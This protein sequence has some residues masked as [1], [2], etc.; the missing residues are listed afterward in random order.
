MNYENKIKKHPWT[1]FG[2]GKKNHPFICKKSLFSFETLEIC[3]KKSNIFLLLLLSR[4]DDEQIHN[5]YNFRWN[6][7][8]NCVVR[9]WDQKYDP[10]KFPTKSLNSQDLPLDT[11][12]QVTSLSFLMNNKKKSKYK[13]M[14]ASKVSQKFSNEFQKL[15]E[16][17]QAKV[18]FTTTTKKKNT[19][20]LFGKLFICSKF[21]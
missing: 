4:G 1:A 8:N 15:K 12:Q 21:F 18:K 13:Q 11:V 3:K 10:I 17:N 20:L 19:V 7:L 16:K 9:F 6:V 14:I 5:S 2:K